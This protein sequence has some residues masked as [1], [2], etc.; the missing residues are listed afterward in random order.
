[1]ITVPAFN[2]V[3]TNH[4]VVNQHVTRYRKDTLFP[5]L[6]QAGLKIEELGI[7]VSV[8]FSR[9]AGPAFDP[10]GVSLA[11]RQSRNSSGIRQSRTLFALCPRALDLGPV[12]SSLWNNSFYQVQ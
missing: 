7:L 1:V 6:K 2:L 12:A 3:W 11:S 9:E 5:L 8:D 10:E 4:D